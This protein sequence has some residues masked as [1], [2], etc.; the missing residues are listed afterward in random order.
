MQA[1]DEGLKYTSK[2]F[3][4]KRIKPSVDEIYSLSE[5]SEALKKV[6]QGKSKGKTIIKFSS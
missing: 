3:D 1:D 4:G 2:L 6:K 5:I